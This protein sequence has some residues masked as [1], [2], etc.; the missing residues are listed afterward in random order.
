ME[1]EFDVVH[2]ILYYIYTNR[3][4]FSTIVPTTK[5]SDP[6]NEPIVTSAAGRPDTKVKPK[7]LP[8]VTDTE[9]IFALAHRLDLVDLQK[10]ALAF[11]GKTCNDENITSRVFSQFA[12]M[13][14]EVAQVYDAYFKEGWPRV[15]HSNE[16]KEY[17]A[18]MEEENNSQ[19]IIRIFAKFRELVLE[20]VPS[21]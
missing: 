5:D 21:D 1:E 4:I 8:R 13:Y 10:L 12:A 11:L 15:A 16:F 9:D 14:D 3:I 17:F 6:S 18:I 19:E 2:N 20:A 7:V